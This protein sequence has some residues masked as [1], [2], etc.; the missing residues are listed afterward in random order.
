MPPTRAPSDL[1]RN[2]I[3]VQITLLPAELAQ[4]DA[5]AARLARRGHAPNRSGA[6]RRAVDHLLKAEADGH[7]RLDPD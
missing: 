4:L 5:L 2:V 6:V 1:G 7:V 3:R